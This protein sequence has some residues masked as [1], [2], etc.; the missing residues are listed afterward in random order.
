MH[1]VAV[2]GLRAVELG[3]PGR[4]A[5]VWAGVGGLSTAQLGLLA[6]QAATLAEGGLDDWISTGIPRAFDL[7]LWGRLWVSR[8]ILLGA[9]CGHHPGGLFEARAAARDGLGSAPRW[10]APRSF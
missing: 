7:G 10:S 8:L 3:G 4:A 2:S 6:V 5:L 9:W 1:F